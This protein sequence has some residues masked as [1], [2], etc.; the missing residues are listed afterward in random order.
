MEKLIQQI[1]KK[2]KKVP[3]EAEEEPDQELFQ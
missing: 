2:D 3:M 1:M